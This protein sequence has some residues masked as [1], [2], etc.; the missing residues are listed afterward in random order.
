MVKSMVNNRVK[1]FSLMEAAVCMLIVGV[2][3]A[4][5]AN[6]FTKRHVTY[7]EADGHGRYECYINGGVLA[8]RYVENNSP[9]SIT[10]NS[11]VFRPPRYAKYFLINAIG[12]GS[13]SGAGTFESLFYSSFSDPITITP[14]AAGGGD[15]VLTVDGSELRRVPGGGGQIVV[16]E[17]SATTVTD[18][19]I[20]QLPVDGVE[21]TC[22]SSLSCSQSG[23]N[24]IVNYCHSNG[25]G[26]MESTTLPLEYVRTNRMGTLPGG[27]ITYKD[28]SGYTERGFSAA[29]AV[30]QIRTCTGADCY[31]VKY[32]M[33]LTFE[34]TQN[35]DS[36]MEAYLD[37]LD[38]HDG[39]ASVNPGALNK[40]G[41]VVILW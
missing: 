17:S 18:C 32:Q 30:S 27:K 10:S 40:A 15:T 3:T 13:A 33:T 31:P 2:F 9:R 1:A 24:I 35:Q 14:G 16:T 37:A 21:Y 38:V 8:Q 29:D 22:G 28:L 11:C 7:Q 20:Q 19:T 36:Q 26:G 34:T 5:C 23:T 41:G 4:M 6:A 12:G 25:T 39:I